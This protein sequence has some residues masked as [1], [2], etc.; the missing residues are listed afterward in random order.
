MRHARLQDMVRGWFVGN[1]SPT[2]FA[3]CDCEVSVRNYAAGE[4][5]AEHFHKV[6]TEI[7]VVVCG[8]V[9][10]LGR[11]WVAGDIVVIEPGET[12]AFEALTDSIN[13]VVKLPGALNDKY[14]TETVCSR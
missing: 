6:A 12:T 9:R 5:E 14:L 10:M 1:F 7:T 11:D 3:T 13:V 8:R 2:V 4:K